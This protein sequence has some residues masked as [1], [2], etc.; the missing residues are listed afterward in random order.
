MSP[1]GLPTSRL[2]V[3]FEN[4]GV[5]NDDLI[6]GTGFPCDA[7]PSIK[8]RLS[9]RRAG[10]NRAGGSL[11]CRMKHTTV[12]ARYTV[13]VTAIVYLLREFVI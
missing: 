3:I 8:L 6:G 5:E 1:A 12:L 7:G 2:S 11:G 4:V 9:R 10:C 13:M